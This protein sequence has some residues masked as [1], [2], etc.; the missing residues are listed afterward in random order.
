MMSCIIPTLASGRLVVIHVWWPL[1]P[2]Y[3]FKDELAIERQTN[4]ELEP[5]FQK[6][7]RILDVDI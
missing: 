3:N 4:A 7:V 2:L 1:Q 6:V 5:S